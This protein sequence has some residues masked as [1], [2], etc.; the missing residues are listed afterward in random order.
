V[1]EELRDTDG[2]RE[3]AEAEA[4]GVVLVHDQ[5]EQS[6][7]QNAPDGNVCEDSGREGPS[8]HHGSTAPVES[9]KVPCQWSGDNWNMDEAGSLVVGEICSREIDEIDDE[10]ELGQPVVGANPEVD[11]AEEEEV[12][13][14]EVGADIGGSSHVGGIVAVEVPDVA[15]LQDEE[16]EPIDAGDD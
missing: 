13:G 14:D 7:D 16:D 2:S 9:N 8:M 10:K 12:V 3:D 11:E 4:H 1:G 15:N 5:E 6:I